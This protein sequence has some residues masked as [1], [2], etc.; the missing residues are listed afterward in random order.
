[1]QRRASAKNLIMMRIGIV[2]VVANGSHIRVLL[3]GITQPSKLPALA[4]RSPRQPA[5]Q[6]RSLPAPQQT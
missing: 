1:M 6:Q 3:A 5:R 2:F 4:P